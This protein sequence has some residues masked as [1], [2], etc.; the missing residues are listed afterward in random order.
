MPDFTLPEDVTSVT[1]RFGRGG[2]TREKTVSCASCANSHALDFVWNELSPV[3]P[4]VL[5][6]EEWLAHPPAERGA[7]PDFAFPRTEAARLISREYSTR[8]LTVQL[9]ADPLAE[10][11]SCLA[12]ETPEPS[13][14]TGQSPS[15]P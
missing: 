6:A 3:P 2:E 9:E 7:P 5:A 12:S 11:S 10:S 8:A 1:F 13:G 4:G 15:T 14:P